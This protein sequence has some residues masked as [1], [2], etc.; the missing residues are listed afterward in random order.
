[1]KLVA[2]QSAAVS[3]TFRNANGFPART[4]GDVSWGTDNPTIATVEAD[5]EDSMKAVVTAGPTA[6]TANIVA[7]ADAELAERAC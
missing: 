1:M 2:T 3:V 5:P 7:S 6:G 4:Q